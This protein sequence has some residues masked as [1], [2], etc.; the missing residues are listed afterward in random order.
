MVTGAAGAIGGAV[1]RAFAGAGAECVGVDV[2]S[3]EGI[4]VCDVASEASV[5]H[6][7]AEAT[8][9]SRLTDVVHAAGV[10]SVGRLEGVPT[11]E[12]RRVLD[13]NLV[14]S[15]FV[16]RAA[17]E[18]VE[19]GGTITLIASQAGLRGG[20]LWSA[21]SASKAGVIRLAESLAQE[22]APKGMRVNAVCPGIVET[23]MLERAVRDL[24]TARGVGE[25]E[26]RQRYVA[27]IP[28]GRFALP[29]EVAGVCVF[30]ASHLASY[31]TGAAIVVDGGELS[32]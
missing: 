3:S 8:A 29:E 7:F 23:P 21:Y 9:G 16:A 30:L 19:K 12:L 22:L 31:V 14:G 6:A 1:C 24:A 10:V 28:L 2:I 15:F 18:S 26:V 25:A 20:A 5:E 32:G 4:L 17:A 11:E 27:G 13:I